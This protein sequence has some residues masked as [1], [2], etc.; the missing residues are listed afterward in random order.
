[1]ESELPPTARTIGAAPV[2]SLG[3]RTLDAPRIPGVQREAT[4]QL[5]K[6]FGV[7]L[8]LFGIV[9]ILLTCVGVSLPSR[10]SVRFIWVAVLVLL[11]GMIAPGGVLCASVQPLRD[12]GRKAP[13]VVLVT[14]L[15]V[16]A[17][18]GF[19]L[20]SAAGGVLMALQ[21][22]EP[23]G[24]G[25]ILAAVLAG[26]LGVGLRLLYHDVRLLAAPAPARAATRDDGDL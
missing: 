2:V 4:S 14:A 21:A 23:V 8:I 18:L 22:G 1:M 9:L 13:I 12:G 10:R 16:A 17:V 7:L 3:Y 24:P 25:L 6:T 19:L 15:F 11:G 26:L 5:C 20:M